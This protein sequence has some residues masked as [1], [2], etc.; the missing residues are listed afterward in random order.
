M[1]DRDLDL[2]LISLEDARR[3]GEDASAAWNLFAMRQPLSK[4]LRLLKWKP[5]PEN[6]VSPEGEDQEQLNTGN[7]VDPKQSADNRREEFAALFP[8]PHSRA[9]KPAA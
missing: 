5:K 7:G 9:P 1:A 3:I 6:A 2:G 4:A 8:N